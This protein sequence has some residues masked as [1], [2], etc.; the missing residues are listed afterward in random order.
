MHKPRSICLSHIG[1]YHV[2]CNVAYI[3]ILDSVVKELAPT[4]WSLEQYII[5]DKWLVYVFKNLLSHPAEDTH[6]GALIAGI[7]QR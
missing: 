6:H 5:C 4:L 7:G 2:S 3:N 1:G